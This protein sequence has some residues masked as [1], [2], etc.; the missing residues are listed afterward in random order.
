MPR[1]AKNDDGVIFLASDYHCLCDDDGRM[2]Q[3]Q[4]T[5]V[6]DGDCG[7]CFFPFFDQQLIVAKPDAGVF[8][9]VND[10]LNHS[11]ILPMAFTFT[12]CI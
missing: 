9:N 2:L 3:Y 10:A 12:F 11:M 5:D 6:F 1:I 4:Y 8:A 7:N